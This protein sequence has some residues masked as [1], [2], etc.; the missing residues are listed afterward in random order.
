[1]L[2]G[3]LSD[4]RASMQ[5]VARFCSLP[6]QLLVTLRAANGSENTLL[7]LVSNSPA[8]TLVRK[9]QF[10]Q[11]QLP[12]EDEK[13]FPTQECNHYRFQL[14]FYLSMSESRFGGIFLDIDISIVL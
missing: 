11:K 10:E 6:L 1:M 9:K 12:V 2:L 14:L 13:S 4:L 7:N 5:C 8:L 3:Y